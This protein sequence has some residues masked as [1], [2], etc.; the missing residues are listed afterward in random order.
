[1]APDILIY[2]AGNDLHCVK[3]SDGIDILMNNAGNDLKYSDGIDILM[4]N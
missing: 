3:Y 1:M 2:N 4:N